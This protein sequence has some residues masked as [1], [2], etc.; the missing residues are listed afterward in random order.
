MA[1]QGKCVLCKT[2]F[3]W[4]KETSLKKL[5]CPTCAPKNISLKRTT[6]I[7]GTGNKP[8]FK[9]RFLENP[10]LKELYLKQ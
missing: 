9:R 5:C 6:D 1:K 7:L 8:R 10:P 2:Y 3:S 4:K